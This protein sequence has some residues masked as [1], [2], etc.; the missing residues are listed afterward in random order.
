M[1]NIYIYFHVVDEKLLEY[2]GSAKKINAVVITSTHGIY[3]L[4]FYV[5]NIIILHSYC[6]H[7]FIYTCHVIYNL[8]RVRTIKT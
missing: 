3:N 7:L 6:T 4:L 1:T 8:F 5:K 2:Y